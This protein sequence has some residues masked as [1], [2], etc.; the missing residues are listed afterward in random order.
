M[1]LLW[2]IIQGT[3]ITNTNYSKDM[4]IRI[5]ILCF[6][7]RCPDAKTLVAAIYSLK[8]IY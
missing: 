4:Y 5:G 1:I 2:F 6:S 7:K 8:D 3:K